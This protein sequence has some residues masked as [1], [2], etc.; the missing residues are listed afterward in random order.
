MQGYKDVEFIFKFV[1]RAVN[2]KMK[3]KMSKHINEKKT[4][5]QIESHEAIAVVSV[6]ATV[7]VSGPGSSENLPA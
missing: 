4:H 1:E 3:I 6:V 2:L 5:T 7:P